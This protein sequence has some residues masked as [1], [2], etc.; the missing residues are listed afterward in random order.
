MRAILIAFGLAAATVAS[1]ATVPPV[2]YSCADGT[3]LVAQFHT[4]ASGPGAVDLTFGAGTKP[5]R[6]P[7][8]MS[9]DGG[10][11]TGKGIEFWIK[12]RGATLTRRAASTTC[13]AAQ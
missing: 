12:G 6:L 13:Q 5:V 11:Y 4:A 7:Q 1:A 2:T 3:S 10:R 8:A 9:A